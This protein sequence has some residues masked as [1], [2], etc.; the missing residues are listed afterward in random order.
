MGLS[1]PQCTASLLGTNP[2]H[3]LP[4][5]STKPSPPGC[6]SLVPPKADWDE[7]TA[8]KMELGPSLATAAPKPGAGLFSRRLTPSLP[9]R[10][11]R[12]PPPSPGELL[13]GPGGTT[14]LLQLWGLLCSHRTPRA[15][16]NQSILH[17]YTFPCPPCAAVV[18]S[19]P[20]GD[21][22][23]VFFQLKEPNVFSCQYL[24]QPNMR[25]LRFNLEEASRDT[26]K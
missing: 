18:E 20:Q 21:K 23:S 15:S 24:V 11:G 17:L 14:E 7:L 8:A 16:V 6:G 26:A 1:C 5:T 2:C 25:C 4:G 3:R 10:D 22:R 9:A 12:W 13:S 19:W